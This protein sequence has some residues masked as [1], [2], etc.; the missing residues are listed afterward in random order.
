MSSEVAAHDLVATVNCKVAG[1]GEEAVSA[2][3]RYARLCEEH[4]RGAR[5]DRSIAVAAQR[6]FLAASELDL[7]LKRRHVAPAAAR[8]AIASFKAEL[9][10]LH[11]TARSALA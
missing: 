5:R 1:C 6:V 10:E 4:R 2:R 8:D 7:A 9:A 3:G 11:A